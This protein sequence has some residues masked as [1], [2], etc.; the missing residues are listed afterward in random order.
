MVTVCDALMFRV[1]RVVLFVRI[2]LM[3]LLIELSQYL[4]DSL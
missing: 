1:Q 3:S 2:L 4:G